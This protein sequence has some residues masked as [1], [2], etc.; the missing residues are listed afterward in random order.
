[1]RISCG[2]SRV[3]I[4]FTNEL[5]GTGLT[6]GAARVGIAGPDGTVL[7]G[8][9]RPVTFGAS[10]ATFVPAGAPAV[11]DPVDLTVSPMATLVVSVYLPGR[12]E[13][14]TGHNLVAGPGWIIPGDHTPTAGLPPAAQPLHGRALLS[15][16]ETFVPEPAVGVVAIGS[17]TTDGAGAIGGGWPELLAARCANDIAFSIAPGE[18]DPEFAGIM[19]TDAPVDAADLLRAHG[20]II[21]R[22]HAHGLTVLGATRSSTSTPC[23]ATPNT[24]PHQGRFPHGRSP[25]RQRRRLCGARGLDRPRVVHLITRVPTASSTS[26]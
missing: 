18:V 23:G 1:M 8:S 6:I 2:G 5:G 11:S 16:V 7:P 9:D 13:D 17:S 10:P 14:V 25:A 4:R 19:K 15:A 20:Q 24:R 26:G 22:A 12:V 3:R 21:E